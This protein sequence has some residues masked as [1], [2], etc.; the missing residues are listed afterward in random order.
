MQ[1]AAEAKKIASTRRRQQQ[2][3]QQHLKEPPLRRRARLRKPRCKPSL[4]TRRE[5]LPPLKQ[6]KKQKK[7]LP[8]KQRKKRF[9]KPSLI[10]SESSTLI[11]RK[12]L[13]ARKGSQPVR[14][15]RRCARR[16]G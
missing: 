10:R 8:L 2:Q 15:T 6:R 11:R 13:S 9:A 3:Q 14:R 4:K 16:K 5:K 1:K 12:R 7:Q